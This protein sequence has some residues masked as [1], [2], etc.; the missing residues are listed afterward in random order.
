LDEYV[1]SGTGCNCGSTGR[2]D[3]LNVESLLRLAF[4]VIDDLDINPFGAGV[5]VHPGEARRDS[6]EVRIGS[7]GA[8]I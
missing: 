6:A 7:G 1:L 4:I 2:I 8:P 3:Y 5:A